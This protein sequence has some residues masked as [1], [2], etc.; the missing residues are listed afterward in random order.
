MN[1][2][3]VF[4]A[5]VAVLTIAGSSFFGYMSH[6]VTKERDV[7]AE[8]TVQTKQQLLEASNEEDRLKEIGT[9]KRL[10]TQNMTGRMVSAQ[11]IANELLSLDKTMV[12]YYHGGLIGN[13]T[14][15]KEKNAVLN[16]MQNVWASY[17]KITGSNDR[18]PNIAFRKNPKWTMTLKSVIPYKESPEVPLLFEMRTAKGKLAG[19]VVATYYVENQQIRHIKR[20]YT[21]EGQRDFV[22]VGGD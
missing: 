2:T 15:K 13:D 18:S 3:N 1:K 5:S 21:S 19:M 11:N 12:Q 17:E 22:D 9:D 7:L 6:N 14:S 20:Y 4:V 10:M 8:Q 16:K